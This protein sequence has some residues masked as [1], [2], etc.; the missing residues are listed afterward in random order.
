MPLANDDR[1][2]TPAQITIAI[3]DDDALVRV[4]LRRLCEAFG[5][6]ARTYASGREFLDSLAD[7]DARPDCLV[8]D[9]HMPEMT[10]FEMLR[11]L[12]AR[13]MRI[14][15]IVCTADDTTEV[16]ARYVGAEFVAY[17]KKPV[18]GDRLRDAIDQAVRPRKIGY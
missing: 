10:G 7:G 16:R 13:G 15:T 2:S 14:P 6:S 4:S 5:W 18:G 3:I 12:T 1:A 8:L 17:L 9:A 11:H